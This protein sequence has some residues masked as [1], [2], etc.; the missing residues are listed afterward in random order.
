MVCV[1]ASLLCGLGAGLLHLLS[2]VGAALA[3]NAKL[4][5]TALSW[6]PYALAF[7]SLPAVVLSAVLV[8]AVAVTRTTGK[9][10]FDAA[11]AIAVVNVVMLLIG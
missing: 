11:I 4:K 8:L 5:S 3:Y 1:I 10:P 9:K 7:G 6:L 2:G